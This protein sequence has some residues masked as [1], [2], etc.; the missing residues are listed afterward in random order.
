MNKV[1]INYSLPSKTAKGQFSKITLSLANDNKHSL[2]IDNFHFENLFNYTNEV[3]ST[4]FEF[5]LFSVLIYNIDK[6][7]PRKKFS[8][9]GWC[10]EIEFDFM[11]RNSEIW[12]GQKEAICKMLAFLTGD[13]WEISFTQSKDV[14]HYIPNGS[15][16]ENKFIPEKICLFSGGLDSLVGIYKLLQEN[17]KTLLVSHYDLDMNGPHN[18]QKEIVE[19]LKTKFKH[20]TNFDWTYNRVGAVRGSSQKLETTFRSRSILFLGMASYLAHNL[21]PNTTLIIP[22]NGTISLNIPLTPSRRSSCSTKTTHPYVIL[23]L[24]KIFIGLGIKT[25]IENPFELETKGEMLQPYSSDLFFKSIVEL[26]NSCGKGGHK[27]WWYKIAVKNDS[28]ITPNHCGKCMPCMYRR[29]AMNKV[30]WDNITPYGDNIFNSNHW[31]F[32]NTKKHKRFKDVK[33][34]LQFIAQNKNKEEIKKELL[35]NGSLPLDKLDNYADVV[36]RT[37]IELKF[38]LNSHSTDTNYKE[39]QKRAKL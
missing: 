31:A 39:L 7:I 2:N 22:E 10:R 38:W 29:A 5:Y 18:D 28:N 25:N 27:R 33:T 37:I 9:D 4:A 21:T 8:L 26:S 15:T 16:I 14:T 36:V 17:N 3:S 23:S 13:I 30:L 35:I 34:L 32:K 24:N 11:V 6:L 12:N 20:F 1:I 19:Q